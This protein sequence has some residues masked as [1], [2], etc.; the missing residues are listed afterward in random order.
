[1]AIDP[2]TG[3]IACGG[4]FDGFAEFAGDTLTSAGGADAWFL[5]VAP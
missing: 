5:A 1:V 2:A 3:R 4:D